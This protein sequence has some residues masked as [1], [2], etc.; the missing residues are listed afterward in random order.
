M[1]HD[2][3]RGHANGPRSRVERG[4]AL[5]RGRFRVTGP[6][7]NAWHFSNPLLAMSA[8]LSR[9][10]DSGAVYVVHQGASRLCV[11]IDGALFAADGVRPI[12]PIEAVVASGR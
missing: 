4:R 5:S 1:E 2:V 12:P 8:A 9:S 7:G 11:A 6:S 10:M 3:V